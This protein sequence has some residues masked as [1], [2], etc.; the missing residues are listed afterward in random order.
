MLPMVSALA[1]LAVLFGSVGMAAAVNTA[2]VYSSGDLHSTASA[3]EMT[4]N[5]VAEPFSLSVTSQVISVDFY[6][7]EVLTGPHTA[8]GVALASTSDAFTGSFYWYILSDNASTPGSVL[9]SG[10]ASIPSIDFSRLDL[11]GAASCPTCGGFDSITN[12]IV[13]PS[14][15]L[16]ANVPYWIAIHNGDPAV[17]QTVPNSGMYW[18]TTNTN[19]ATA[20]HTSFSITSP[21][22]LSGFSS[23]PGGVDLTHVYRVTGQNCGPTDCL[24]PDRVPEPGTLALLGAGMG[25]I[26]VVRRFRG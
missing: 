21:P 25:L 14:V 17:H 7:R 20:V 15:L 8:S 24:P 10:V 11:A 18:D 9:Y 16:T 13:I 26:G 3:T 4:A 19:N 23:S 1:A 2:T 22:A 6:T 12:S 5:L